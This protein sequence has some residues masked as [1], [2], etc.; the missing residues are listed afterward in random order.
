MSALCIDRLPPRA[1]V[2][3]HRTWQTNAFAYNAPFWR[4]TLDTCYLRHR[5]GGGNV[6]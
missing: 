6:L 1:N 5:F 4:I 3:A 2:P